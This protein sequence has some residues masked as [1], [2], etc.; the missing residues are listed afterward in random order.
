MKSFV[1]PDGRCFVRDP[2]AESLAAVTHDV[3]CSVDES[4]ME[5]YLALGFAVHRREGE[6]LVPTVAKG[7]RPDGI[8]FRRADEIDE[9]TLRTL[10]NELRQDVP[11]TDG[12]RWDVSGFHEE[13]YESP[14]FDPA[15][16]LVAVDDAAREAV[17]I[18]R[19]WMRPNEPKL[20]FIGV[21]AA[22]R[23]RGIALALLAA[24]FAELRARGVD[25]VTT[26]IDEANIASRALLEGLGARRTGTSVELLRS[27]SSRT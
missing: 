12:W 26:T 19:V 17:G 16:Y 22:Y 18:V 21:T 9:G 8:S 10:D 13:T 1:R 20:G 15:T 2:D 3:Y 25:E 7:E 24:V 4:Q 27:W 6:Y 5:P 23:R 11:G 14:H